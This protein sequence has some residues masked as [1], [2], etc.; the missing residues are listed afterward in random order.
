M[1]EP[2]SFDAGRVKVGIPRA[3]CSPQQTGRV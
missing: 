3:P 2:S 1:R